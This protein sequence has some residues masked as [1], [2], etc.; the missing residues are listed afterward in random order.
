M[1][2]LKTPGCHS[3]LFSHLLVVPTLLTM[4]AWNMAWRVHKKQWA[5]LSR[6]YVWGP[7]RPCVACSAD[8]WDLWALLSP[9][10]LLSSHTGLFL[11]SLCSRSLMLQS[12]CLC[13]S[14]SRE[15][16]SQPSCLSGFTS[17]MTSSGS[18]HCSSRWDM[19]PLLSLLSG[20]GCVTPCP[21][22]LFLVLS[23][24]PGT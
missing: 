18:P 9:S 10:S 20:R 11:F 17:Y 6:S 5:C 1:V 12:L 19:V 21:I 23:T 2:T 24:G 7:R 3:I 14:L 8:L 4:E 13:F 16:S 22:I 15:V